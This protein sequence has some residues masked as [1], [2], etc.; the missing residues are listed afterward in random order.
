MK[1]IVII[2]TY[3]EKDNIEPLVREVFATVPGIHIMVTDDSSPDG[4]GQI[5]ERLQGEF[6]KLKLYK[7]SEKNGLGAAYIASFAKILS[8]EIDVEHIIMMDGD[9]SL[10]PRYLPEILRLG[11]NHDMVIGSRYINGGRIEEWTFRRRVLSYGASIYLRILLS[12]KIR[13][14]TCGYCCIKKSALQK[15]NLKEIT[16]TGYA[17]ISGL[18]YYILKSGADVV[19]TPITLEAR[20]G[21]ESKMS[22]FVIKEGIIGPWQILLKNLRS[23]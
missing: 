8:E 21:G 11:E 13:D 18:K 5:V 15:I 7:R 20:R 22:G 3:N 23:R 9:Y 12:P 19:E 10:H 4:T 16:F 1:D 17:F 14:W 2:P 6:P